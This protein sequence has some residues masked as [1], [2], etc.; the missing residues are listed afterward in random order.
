MELNVC[1]QTFLRHFNHDLT[2]LPFCNQKNVIDTTRAPFDNPHSL[3]FPVTMVT[4]PPRLDDTYLLVP[5]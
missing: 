2:C 3:T 1:N 4:S 5:G